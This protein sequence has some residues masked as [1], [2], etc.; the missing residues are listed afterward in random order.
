MAIV[1]DRVVRPV[2]ALQLI[3][4]LGDQETADAVACHE[5]KLTLEEVETAERGKLIEHQQKLLPP[6]VSIQTLGQTPSDL[7][8]NETH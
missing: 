7:I 3:Q 1:K 2:S 5:G 6:S 4:A 8:E